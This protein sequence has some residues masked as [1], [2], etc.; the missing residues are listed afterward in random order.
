MDDRTRRAL[1]D[2]EKNA[3]VMRRHRNVAQ[4]LGYVSDR[5]AE[6]AFEKGIQ[7]GNMTRDRQP[8]EAKADEQDQHD[9]KPEARHRLTEHR[10]RH[11]AAVDS[12]STLQRGHDA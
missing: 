8:A 11:D 10:K 7:H 3:T 4:R 6:I 9:T 1:R 5:S 12:G 2:S